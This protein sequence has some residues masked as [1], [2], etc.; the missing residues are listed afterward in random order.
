ARFGREPLVTLLGKQGAALHDYATGDEHEPVSPAAAAAP[1]KSVG[2]GLTFK[3]NLLGWED[4]RTGVTALADEV[5]ARLRR[6]GLRCATIQVTIRDP[7]FKD[8]CRQK[9]LRTPSYT[10]RE[11]GGAAM[12]LITASWNMKNPIRALTITGQSLVGEDEVT[13][14]LSLFEEDAAP[15]RE[16]RERL[17]QAMDRIRTKYGEEAITFT[18]AVKD[19]LG[20]AGDNKLPPLDGE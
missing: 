5:A 19:E 7:G 3:R 11:I 16:R 20:L 1:P 18:S 12:E 10:A 14:Q 13:E 2:S 6:H 4:V 15:R 9:P 8:I 17:E